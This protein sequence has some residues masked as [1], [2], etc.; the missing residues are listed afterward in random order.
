MWYSIEDGKTIGQIGSENGIIIADEEFDKNCR[1]TIEKDGCMA[2]YS[3]TCGV[4]G[5][6]FHTTFAGTEDEI[7][8][9]Y[10]G[11]KQELQAFMES[12]E[13]ES[14]WCEKFTSKW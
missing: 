14:E 4:Y 1:I 13:D 8:S 3:I 12:N 2:P 11:M 10:E 5:L 6:I 9:K 7:K